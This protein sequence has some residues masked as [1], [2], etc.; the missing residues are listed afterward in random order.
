MQYDH[1]IVAAELY[2]SFE[3]QLAVYKELRDAVRANMSRLILSRGNAGVLQSG[4]DK[5]MRLLDKINQER[6]NIAGHIDF[7][8]E[9]RKTAPAADAAT[10]KLNEIL[11]QTEE[12]IKEFLAEEE[13][14]KVYVEKM[15]KK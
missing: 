13:K 14:L 11:A 2:A 8:Q 6:A 1:K 7:W 10:V 4:V 12:V 3:R 9:H 5:K 15:C